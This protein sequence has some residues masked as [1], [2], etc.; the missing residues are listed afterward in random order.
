MRLPLALASLLL[1]AGC[2]DGPG[3]AISITGNDSD[4]GGG[5]AATATKSGEI[6][7]KAPGFSGNMKLPAIKLD[8]SNFDLNG[9]KLPPGSSIDT[10]DIG[11][12]NGAEGLTVR[13]SSPIS[14]AAVHDWF[15]PKLQA[16]GFKLADSGSGLTGT[17]EDGKPFRLTLNP[18]GGDASTGEITIGR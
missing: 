12:R 5:F 11:A 10:L 9:V 6:A 13:F 18:S 15:A 14:P 3:T 2:G 16:A 8:A 1:L 7:I 4:S 17:T